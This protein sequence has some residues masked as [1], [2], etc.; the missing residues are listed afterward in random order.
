MLVPVFSA[1]NIDGQYPRHKNW[2]IMNMLM[3]ACKLVAGLPISIY[4]QTSPDGYLWH[5]KVHPL[6]AIK[7]MIYTSL[8]IFCDGFHKAG[9]QRCS[10][11]PS[12]G[13]G[14]LVKQSTGC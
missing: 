9:P 13:Y 12:A 1:T 10:C 3:L 8:N 6:I 5:K 7:L 14:F 11:F 2:Q 4:L